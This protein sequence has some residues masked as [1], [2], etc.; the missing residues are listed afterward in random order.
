MAFSS[1]DPLGLE[2]DITVSDDE[3]ALL[4]DDLRPA[5]ILEFLVLSWHVQTKHTIA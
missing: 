3:I 2:L 4:N 1:P 5:F